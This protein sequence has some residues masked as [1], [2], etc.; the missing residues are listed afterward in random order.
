M[1]VCVYIHV[2]V[3]GEG[4]HVCCGGQRSTSGVIPRVLSTLFCELGSLSSMQSTGLRGQLANK[5]KIFVHFRFSSAGIVSTCYH[6]WHLKYSCGDQLGS[7]YLCSKHYT[8][9]AI[10]LVHGEDYQKHNQTRC[11]RISEREKKSEN[12]YR[13]STR[14]A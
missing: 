14:Q 2:C 11:F 3:C 6:T 9:K 4:G 1:C 12:A 10:A 5:L 8:N 7:L 13:L